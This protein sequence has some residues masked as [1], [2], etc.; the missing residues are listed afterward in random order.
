MT[1]CESIIEDTNPNEVCRS[2]SEVV[3]Y[4]NRP[5]KILSLANDIGLDIEMFSKTDG[6]KRWALSIPPEIADG[7][8]E[9]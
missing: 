2:D 4:W 1:F 3:L 7:F 6:G 8:Y 9:E 5:V